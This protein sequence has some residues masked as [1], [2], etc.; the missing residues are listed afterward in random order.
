MQLKSIAR[1][2]SRFRSTTPRRLLILPARRSRA[3]DF[4]HQEDSDHR[5]L[6]VELAFGVALP[7][8]RRRLRVRAEPFRV[9]RPVEVPQWHG[10]RLEPAIHAI[11]APDAGSWMSNTSR[12]RPSAPRSACT[13]SRSSGCRSAPPGC[14]RAARPRGGPC[15]RPTAARC[16]SQHDVRQAGSRTSWGNDSASVRKRFTHSPAAALTSRSDGAR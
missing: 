6:R 4:I 1:C 14:S 9:W 16:R 3:R 12:A 2:S 5:Q 11:G 15:I 10:A 7:A 13:R 8:L